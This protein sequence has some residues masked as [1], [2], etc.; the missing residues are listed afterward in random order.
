MEKISRLGSGL[1]IL[2]GE[3]VNFTQIGF[4]LGKKPTTCCLS[5]P[6]ASCRNVADLSVTVNRLTSQVDPVCAN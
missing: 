5:E 2:A 6:S 1:N 4:R 3:N